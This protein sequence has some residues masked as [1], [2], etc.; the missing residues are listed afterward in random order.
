MITINKLDWI[1]KNTCKEF[2]KDLSLI[3]WISKQDK[4]YLLSM[5]NGLQ[6]EYKKRN[7]FDSKI[8]SEI[9]YIGYLLRS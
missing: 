8:E 9:K 7:K 1:R 3:N 6:L 2:N 5:F 4:D